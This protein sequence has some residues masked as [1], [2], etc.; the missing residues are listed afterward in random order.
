MNEVK[1]IR[2]NFLSCV[3][4]E[5]L[6]LKNLP[7]FVFLCGG[8]TKLVQVKGRP[9]I[10]KSMRKAILDIIHNIPSL[11]NKILL[12]EEYQ[13]WLEHGVIKNLIDFEL[14]IADMAGAIVLIL[15]GPG[16]YAELGSFSVLD[17]LS[18]KLILVI[19]NKIIEDNSYINLG[20]I[21]YLEDN[22]KIVLKY[23]WDVKYIVRGVNL[24]EVDMHL[25][26]QNADMFA[27]A[28]LIGNKINDK[29]KDITLTSP[30]LNLS[31]SGHVCFVIGDL[32]YNFGALRVHEIMS[33]LSDWFDI[34]GVTLSLVK[35]Y[36]YIL[37]EF[38]FIKEVDVGDKF[39]SPTEKNQGFI[40]YSYFDSLDVETG[41]KSVSEIKAHMIGYYAESDAARF[42]AALG[43]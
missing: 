37:N 39:Y 42:E 7:N 16:A 32:I 1:D 20:P 40:K 19:N 23:S 27:K 5:K 21:K 36:L 17:T 38:D 24:D 26:G 31:R 10:Y 2:E 35:S 22:S 3:D 13:G 28:S 15:E 33:Y 29:V 41:C 30:Q 12:A 4:Y 9:D 18:D 25:T 34:K 6:R 14:A 8:T 11:S 43:A